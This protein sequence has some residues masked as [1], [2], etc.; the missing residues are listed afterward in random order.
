MDIE[1]ENVDIKLL[2]KQRDYLLT[3]PN[4]EYI[5]GLIDLLNYILDKSEIYLF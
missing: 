2:E 4:N 3:L 5:N 1:I